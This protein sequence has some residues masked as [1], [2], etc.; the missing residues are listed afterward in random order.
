MYSPETFTREQT[1]AVVSGSWHG[2][3]IT[4]SAT[5]NTKGS[6]TSLITSL[7]FDAYLCE[8]II[9]ELAVAATD[10]SC[11]VDIGIDSAGGTSYTVLIPDILAGGRAVST[12]GATSLVFPIF[13]PRGAQLA[14]RMQS[15]IASDVARVGI[16]VLGGLPGNAPRPFRSAIQAYG[17]TSSGASSGTVMANAAVDT[18]GAWTQLG[19]DLTRPHRG[20]T[21]AC[22]TGDSGVTSNRY[23]VD[24]GI[25]PAGG[26][27][28]TA[29]ISD[30]PVQFNANEIAWQQD[31]LRSRRGVPIPSGA[32][33]A[34][35]A[36][37]STAN[38]QA[39]LEVAV[40]GW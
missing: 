3:Q 35:R 26:T 1:S 32:A 22:A 8:V 6:Y 21:V 16:R 27:S 13:A 23:L 33:I 40:Y 18:K 36:A 39:D 17:V 9:S 38:I 7:N 20:L 30:L 31:S 10:T 28:Y 37:A 4:A 25:D 14:A 2:P 12:Q 15:V 5:T 11:L 29:V 19:A 24:I 34:A